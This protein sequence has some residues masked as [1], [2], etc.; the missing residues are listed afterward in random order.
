MPQEHGVVAEARGHLLTSVDQHVGHNDFGA[1]GDEQPDLG[2][3]LPSRPTGDNRN[4]AVESPHE[5]P[6]V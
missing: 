2:L 5:I 3:A 6:L 1:L 4:L